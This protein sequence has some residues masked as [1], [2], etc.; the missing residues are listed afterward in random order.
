MEDRK[1]IIFISKHPSYTANLKRVLY[2][3]AALNVLF[4]ILF[5]WSW[6]RVIIVFLTI[7]LMDL[8]TFYLPAVTKKYVITKNSI[9][10]KSWFGSREIPF[11][12]IGNIAAAK[13]KILL[14]SMKGKVLLKIYEIYLD[15]S[16][17]EEFKDILFKQ[18][19]KHES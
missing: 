5:R 17:R 8:V 16:V 2:T 3:G 18:F 13:G 15:Q 9:M 1:D 6:T 14:V 7:A 12:Q 4:L 11:S 10:R 19:E